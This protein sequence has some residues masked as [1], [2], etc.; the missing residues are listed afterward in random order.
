MLMRPLR[1]KTNVL[2]DEYCKEKPY[3]PTPIK[4]KGWA[5]K[6][7]YLSDPDGPT[8]RPSELKPPYP[9][10]TLVRR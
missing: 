1:F 7:T 3:A 6:K 4:G 8:K 5:W 10:P 9:K 2:A